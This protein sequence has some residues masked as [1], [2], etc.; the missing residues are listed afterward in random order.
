MVKQANR[1]SLQ[2]AC[3]TR[4][5]LSCTTLSTPQ[6]LQ[7]ENRSV[8]ATHVRPSFDCTSLRTN[9]MPGTTTF[10]L[11]DLSRR[12]SLY[13]LFLAAAR[14]TTAV[15]REW[16]VAL[17]VHYSL[18]LPPMRCARRRL[19]R[20]PP[21]FVPLYHISQKQKEESLSYQLAATF[22]E[23]RPE[24][25]NGTSYFATPPT[26]HSQI[27]SCVNQYEVLK[28]YQSELPHTRLDRKK[29]RH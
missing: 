6:L 20:P 16:V 10:L 3:T 8:H 24:T 28:R 13:N 11:H 18:V 12:T 27:P 14:V 26:H 7:G 21:S 5:A 19:P 23:R 9:P 4:R 15:R 25:T 2:R 17:R 1:H 29:P 22:C